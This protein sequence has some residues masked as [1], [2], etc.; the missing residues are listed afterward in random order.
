[1][2]CAIVNRG[3]RSQER[4]VKKAKGI[5]PSDLRKMST[6]STKNVEIISSAYPLAC[7]QSDFFVRTT[8][9]EFTSP[10]GAGVLESRRGKGW[11]ALVRVMEGTGILPLR[12]RGKQD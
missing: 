10:A 6:R 2:N 1:M 11:L 3:K 8:A 12:H 4:R 5:K 7:V 9:V